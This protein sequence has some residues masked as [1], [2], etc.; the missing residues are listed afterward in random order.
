MCVQQSLPEDSFIGASH[1]K[2]LPLEDEG[3]VERNYLDDI[4]LQNIT[5]FYRSLFVAHSSAYM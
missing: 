3:W 1:V 2:F 4:L 5:P